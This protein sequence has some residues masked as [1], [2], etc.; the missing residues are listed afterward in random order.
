MVQ[1]VSKTPTEVIEGGHLKQYKKVSLDYSN[2]IPINGR[3][4]KGNAIF[5]DGNDCHSDSPSNCEVVAQETY[6]DLSIMVI[7]NRELE[8]KEISDF[9]NKDNLSIK[10]APHHLR[11][12]WFKYSNENASSLC[13]NGESDSYCLF[14]LKIHHPLL[15][16]GRSQN[17]VFVFEHETLP[18][19][20]DEKR[21]RSFILDID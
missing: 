11:L 19:V 4:K 3:S 8:E 13:K 6:E 16:T 1:P 12:T 14:V 21:L 5:N 17:P 7:F 20:V 15:T 2:T 18:N 9:E 10:V